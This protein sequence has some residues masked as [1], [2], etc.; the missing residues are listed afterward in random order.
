MFTARA[1]DFGLAH[2]LALRA[3]CEI[4][5]AMT[6]EMR[7]AVQQQRIRD[8]VKKTFPRADVL[9]DTRFRPE[10]ISFTISV[11][12]QR[13]GTFTGGT[14]VSYVQELTDDEIADR[15]QSL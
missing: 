9:F 4:G 11:K 3:P 14:D 15:I 1:L 10:A 13:I 2:A 5:R 12:G 6:P 8:V 7:Y